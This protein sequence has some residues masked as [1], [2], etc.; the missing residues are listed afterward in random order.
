MKFSRAS[1][2]AAFCACAFGFTC[3]TRAGF[4]EIRD[5]PTEPNQRQILGHILGG[6]FQ[7]DGRSFTNG[8]LRATRLDDD[9]DQTFAGNRFVANVVAR[10]SDYSQSF[11][12]MDGGRFEKLFDI[13]GNHYNVSGQAT[14]DMTKGGEFARSGD[15]STDSSNISENADHR[16]H[17]ITYQIAGDGAPDRYMLFWEDLNLS[18]TLGKHRTSA[19]FNDL[20]IELTATDKG[21]NLVPLPP[22]VA[23]GATLGVCILVIRYFRRVRVA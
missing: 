12:C 15:S 13:T 5:N 20:V 16:D 9:E 3:A 2:A 23:T 8:T 17:L 14:I 6:D 18:P 1:F 10:F 7:V 11:G 4:T 19:D 22:A 21:G